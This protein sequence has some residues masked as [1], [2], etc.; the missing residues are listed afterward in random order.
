[1]VKYL[2]LYFLP[3]I[4]LFYAKICSHILHRPNYTFIKIFFFI[5]YF[6]I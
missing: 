5:K 1:M 6:K 2:I 4:I 3:Q